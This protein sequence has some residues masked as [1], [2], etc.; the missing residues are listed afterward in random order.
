MNES[1]G[2]RDLQVISERVSK[3]YCIYSKEIAVIA[4][5]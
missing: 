1:V 4:F 3:F 2:E 5:C